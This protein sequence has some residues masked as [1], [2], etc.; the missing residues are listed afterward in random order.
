MVKNLSI[1]LNKLRNY[2]LSKIPNSEA[3][4]INIEGVNYLS[5]RVRGNLL[6]DL[7]ITDLITETYI[8]LEFKESEEVIN[9]LSNFNF[10][11]IGTVVNELQSKVKYLPKSLVISWSK[12]SDTVYVLLEPSTNFPPVK[13]SLRGGE[14]M[15]ITPS[16][17]VRGEDVTCS[18]EV[19]QV[20]AKVVIKLL[21]ELPN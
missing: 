4:L 17:I 18:D 11:Y 13:G 8:G 10:P 19:H 3:T 16:C 5:L 1:D 9:T 14:V 15:V 6:F 20:I 21:K 12:P 2:L 7:R